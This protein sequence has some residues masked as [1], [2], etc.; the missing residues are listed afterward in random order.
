M[1]TLLSAT[2]ERGQGR[3]GSI[4]AAFTSIEVSVIIFNKKANNDSLTGI[5]RHLSANNNEEITSL[6]RS[7]EPSDSHQTV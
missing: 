7:I 5:H 2:Q 3:G 4:E 1:S 6:V